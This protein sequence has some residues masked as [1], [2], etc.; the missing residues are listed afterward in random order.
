SLFEITNLAELAVELR[1]L[2]VDDLPD[3][4]NLDRN[5]QQLVRGLSYELRQPV[6]RVRR[7]REHFVAVPASAPLPNLVRQLVPHVATLVPQE[8]TELLRFDRPSETL[9]PIARAYLQFA[10][11]SPLFADRL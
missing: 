4:E 2:R 9:G 1:L 10:L 6:A 11:G 5:I 8:I 3:D 7:G